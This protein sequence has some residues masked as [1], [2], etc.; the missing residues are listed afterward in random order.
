MNLP[1]VRIGM[2]L[3]SQGRLHVITDSERIAGFIEKFD[4]CVCLK[5]REETAHELRAV[6]IAT[7]VGIIGWVNVRWLQQP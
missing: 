1:D 4:L 5:T 6:K 7:T 3:K 2:L